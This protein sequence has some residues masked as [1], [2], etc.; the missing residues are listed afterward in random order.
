MNPTADR[1]HAALR[2]LTTKECWEHLAENNLGRIAYVDRDGPC[3]LPFNY[4]A[5]NGEIWLR[6]ASYSALAVDLPGERAAF[7]VDYADEHQ[8]SGW[9]V[10]VRGRA[11]HVL[12]EDYP[13]LPDQT[14]DPTP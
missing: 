11:E 5:H 3:L 14:P 13:D 7:A 1:H 6:T 9:S 12:S 4:V 2:E 10:M 8:R